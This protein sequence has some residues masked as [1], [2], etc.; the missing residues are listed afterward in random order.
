MS[1]HERKGLEYSAQV[2]RENVLASENKLISTFG[3]YIAYSGTVLAIAISDG[4]SFILSL[5]NGILGVIVV[6]I[7]R[8]YIVW[9]QHYWGVLKEIAKKYEIAAEYL[10][11]PLLPSRDERL[12]LPRIDALYLW[13]SAVT[14]I[15]WFVFAVYQLYHHCGCLG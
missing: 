2:T 1:K 15:S 13:C 14:M 4:D 9:K 8:G 12:R 7:V 10:P 11:A 3:A 6:F 5:V